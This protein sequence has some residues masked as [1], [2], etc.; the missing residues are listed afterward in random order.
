[1]SEAI[2]KDVKLE[3][4]REGTCIQMLHSG[5]YAKEPETIEKMRAAAEEAGYEFHGA[6]HE[7]YLSDPRRVAPENLKTILRIPALRIRN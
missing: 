5:S 3:T 2:L 7:I 4:I 6:H 1:M